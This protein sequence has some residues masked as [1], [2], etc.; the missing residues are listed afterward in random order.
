LRSSVADYEVIRGLPANGVGQARY[1]CRPPE[2]L[3]VDDPVMITELAV[4]A[5][6]W[7]ELA[8]QLSRLAG[9]G[10]DRL[11]TLYEVGPDLDA[12]GAGVYLVYEAAPGGSADDPAYPLDGVGRVRAVAE[13]ARGAHAL[14]EAGIV[15][16]SVGS[17]SIFL[18][19]RGAVLGPPTFGRPPGEVARMRDWQ[20]LVLLDP[21]LLRGED[22]SRSSDLWAL[23]ATLHGLL[24]PRPLYPGIASDPAVTA[25]Q[26][27]LFTRPEIDPALP[28]DVADT[29]VVF[30]ADDPGERPLTAEDLA[31]RLLRAG[32]LA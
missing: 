19:P 27:V 24:S 18:T 8:A 28:A 22:P 23:A 31:N 9:V 21:A 3:G 11:L 4:D 14:H 2:R 30:L 25:V 32:A 7:R 20:S 15:H 17:G 10:S 29:L 13:A 26:R 12:Q 6:G 16:G 1:L 5:A